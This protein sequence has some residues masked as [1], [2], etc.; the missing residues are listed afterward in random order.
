MLLWGLLLGL[1]T[2]KCLRCL[3]LGGFHEI[4][5]IIYINKNARNC[6]Y[7]MK[8]SKRTT[9]GR[10]RSELQLS[11]DPGHKWRHVTPQQ[12]CLIS[13]IIEEIG[14]KTVFEQFTNHTRCDLQPQF[15]VAPLNDSRWVQKIVIKSQT[16]NQQKQKKM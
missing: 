2:E 7:V 1:T 8:L 16:P 3:P 11:T 12:F 6:T 10:E 5:A 4:A 13:N 15:N 9:K 14:G